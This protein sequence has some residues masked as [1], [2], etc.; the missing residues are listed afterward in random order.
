MRRRT[1]PVSN[2]ANH[3]EY[4]RLF[5]L[6]VHQ[7]LALA[8]DRMGTAGKWSKWSPMKE[9]DIS[10]EMARHIDEV[11]DGLSKPWMRFLSLEPE[12][13]VD[14]PHVPMRKRRIGKH[15]RRMDFRFRCRERSPI[16]RFVYE[17]KLLTDSGSYQDLI[18]ESGLQRFLDSRYARNDEVAGL[19]GY[20]QISTEATHAQRVEAALMSDKSAYRLSPTG[21]WKPVK[22]PGLA[23]CSFTT[24]HTRP[25]LAEI[26]IYHTFLRFY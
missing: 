16:L 19:L 17:A 18:G 7:L 11:L 14:E 10:G 25:R 22:W 24:K 1:T 6:R 23:L 12:R 26:E 20:V 15:R 8:Y 9:E 5:V 21:D 13:H 3:G 4:R 2:N